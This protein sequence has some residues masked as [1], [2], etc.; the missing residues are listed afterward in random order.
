MHAD[1]LYK[2]SLM[3]LYSESD[4]M[5]VKLMLNFTCGI[6]GQVVR[7]GVSRPRLDQEYWQTV[8]GCETQQC[9]HM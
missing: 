4:Y 9:V 2:F 7:K 6:E 1:G 8:Q 5:V 3:K